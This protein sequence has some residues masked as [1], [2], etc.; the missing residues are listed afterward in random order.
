MTGEQLLYDYL[1]KLIAEVDGAKLDVAALPENLQATGERLAFLGR[2]LEDNRKMIEA[3]NA[4]NLEYKGSEDGDLHLSVSVKSLQKNVQAL[5]HIAECLANG[6]YNLRVDQMG[7]FSSSFEVM[8]K[9]LQER[10]E[11]LEKSALTDALT[12]IANRM[13]FIHEADALWKQGKRFYVTFIDM[14]DLKLR[15]DNY[16]HAEGDKLIDKF[17]KML[18]ESFAD[19][20]C[21]HISGDEF[22]VIGDREML[23]EAKSFLR[24]M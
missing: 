17:A 8:I 7:A 15:N 21:Y 5:N 19:Y 12:G 1:Q 20:K 11:L 6:K 4:G 24:K 2:C 18:K 10:K 3:L 22:A 16:G 9:Q 14:D 13:S 23:K